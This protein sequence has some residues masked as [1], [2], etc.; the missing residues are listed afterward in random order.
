MNDFIASNVVPLI[1]TFAVGALGGVAMV[2]WSWGQM[3]TS[4]GRPV[5]GM[6]HVAGLRTYGKGWVGGGDP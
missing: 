3:L 1:W 2:T 4:T 5:S 6:R